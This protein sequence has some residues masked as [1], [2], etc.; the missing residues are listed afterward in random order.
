MIRRTFKELL[1]SDVSTVFLNPL[2]FGESHLIDGE[3]MTVAIDGMEVVERSKKQSEH[4]RIAGVYQQQIVLY[5]AKNEFGKLPA[6]GRA[7]MLDKG[8]YRVTDA[9]DEGGIYSITLGAVKS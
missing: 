5:V 3:K 8:R 4:G 1:M 9:I 7:I 6:I 2:E